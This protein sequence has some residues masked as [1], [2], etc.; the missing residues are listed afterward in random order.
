[1]PLK[2]HH[3]K[4][5]DVLRALNG[6]TFIWL[7]LD[8][9]RG[10]AHDIHRAFC[11]I[12][13]QT[14]DF[15]DRTRIVAGLF[16]LLPAL[17]ITAGVYTWRCGQRVYRQTGIRAW[18]QFLGQ[19]DAGLRFAVP[20]PWYYMFEF[21]FPTHRMRASEYLYFFELKR[22]VYHELRRRWSQQTTLDALSDKALFS[23]HCARH[24][25]AVVPV[26]AVAEKGYV[27]M[28]NGGDTLP[29]HDLFF[30]PRKGAGGRDASCWYY[31]GAGFFQSADAK[32]LTATQLLDNLRALSRES[33]FI[34]RPLVTNHPALS[35]LNAG[36]LST[37][38]VMTCRTESGAVVCTHALLR[39]ASTKGSPVD[40]FHKGGLAAAIE[41][42]NGV[43]G[44]AT[45]IGWSAG[46]A[47]HT[48][49]PVSGAAIVGFRLPLWEET[50]AL[51]RQ[52]HDA[53]DDQILVGWDIAILADRPALV[54]GNKG[55][56]LDIIQRVYREPVGNGQ[57]GRS[58]A[59]YLSCPNYA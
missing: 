1:M 12:Y 52:A 6:A 15:I 19:I 11:R 42:D 13:W 47:W 2:K 48:H 7:R 44:E 57:I 56:D 3:F 54:E 5:V 27:T 35:E 32:Q 38:R 18:R 45:D 41:L 36:A 39:M 20:P 34:V 49:H 46:S 40:N 23:R 14:S 26:V 59:Y 28:E 31:A 53:F 10:P 58:L 16:F 29:N 22:A 43:L 51:A 50:L 17:L 9:R 8:P 55:P 37:V 25:L 4:G 30:K 24:G 21:Y 33:D